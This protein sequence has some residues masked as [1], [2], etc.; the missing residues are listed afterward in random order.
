MEENNNEQNTNVESN[1]LPVEEN[2]TPENVVEQPMEQTIAEEPIQAETVVVP[3][4]VNINVESKKKKSK[5]PIIIAIV[6]I[7]LVIAGGVFAYLK[8]DKKEENKDNETKTLVIDYDGKSGKLTYFYKDENN[9]YGIEEE[10]DSSKEYVGKY[11]CKTENCKVFEFQYEKNN[12]PIVFIYDNAHYF[13]YDFVND[14][15]KEIKLPNLK[16]EKIYSYDENGNIVLFQEKDDKEQIAFYS[17]KQNKLLVKFED[18]Y[19]DIVEEIAGYIV[20]THNYCETRLLDLNSGKLLDKEFTGLIDARENT[21]FINDT[22]LCLGAG[23]ELYF[24]KIYTKD[25]ELIDSFKNE[26]REVV[27]SNEGTINYIADE[28]FKSIKDNKITYTSKKYNKVFAVAEDV[29]FVNDNGILSVINYNEEKIVDFTE[30][31][32]DVK[33][34]GLEGPDYFLSQ[35]DNVVGATVEDSTLKYEDLDHEYVIEYAE[36]EAD[37]KFT[38]E[39]ALEYCKKIGEKNMYSLGYDYSY[40]LKTKKLTKEMIIIDYC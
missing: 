5:M 26:T 13:T 35:T 8:F 2:V 18:G 3:P 7:L 4:K 24:N 31:N 22:G 27:I 36:T 9:S 30:L 33:V 12:E 11:I 38:Y 10:K 1:V 21:Y 25:G 6:L 15:E 32:K 17:T 34:F 29:V 39:E 28:Q 19:N 16:Y 37:K 20:F 23:E 40:D 14:E